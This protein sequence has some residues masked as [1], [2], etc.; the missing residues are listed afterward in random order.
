MLSFKLKTTDVRRSL[1]SGHES[2]IFQEGYSPFCG[3]GILPR[4]YRGWKPLPQRTS[5]LADK[6]ALSIMPA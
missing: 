1:L 3:S 4:L 2:Q 5:L 6:V